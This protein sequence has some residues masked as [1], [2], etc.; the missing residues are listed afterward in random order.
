MQMQKT[1]MSHTSILFA[2][3]WLDHGPALRMCKFDGTLLSFHIADVHLHWAESNGN[4]FV[5]GDYFSIESRNFRFHL[6]FQ[7]AIKAAECFYQFLNSNGHVIANA[8]FID[9]CIRLLGATIFF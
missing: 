3:S 1:E 9:W 2:W 4:F 5:E 7:F 8:L 6:S